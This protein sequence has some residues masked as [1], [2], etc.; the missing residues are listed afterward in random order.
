MQQ[1]SRAAVIWQL[2]A[3]VA[4]LLPHLSWLP[5]WLIATCGLTLGAR[6]MIHGGRWPLPHWSLKV[7]LVLLV[8]IGLLL[9][10][11]RETGMRATVALLIGGLALKMLEIY[12][13]RDA[14]VL[15][16]VALFV[17]GTTFL[18]H[19]SILVALYVLLAVTL[20]VAALNSIYQDP[21]RTD[22]WRPLKRAIR[23]LGFALPMMLV[24]FVL[25]PRIGP[26]WSVPLDQHAARSGLSEEMAPG[27]ISQLTKSAQLAFRAT[28]E[29]PPPAPEQRY[30]R[31]LVLSEFDGR[32]WRRAPFGERRRAGIEALSSTA[33]PI[34]YEV[35]FEPSNQRWL[36]ALD[37]PLS[38]S[39]GIRLGPQRTLVNER[40]LDRRISYSVRSALNYQLAERLEP[41]S[42]AA[43]LQLP[44]RGN[45]QSRAQAQS[46]W[47]E[48]G[49]DPAGFVQRVLRYFNQRFV[50]T[51]SPPALSDNTVDRF[52]FDTQAG[53]CG[54]YAGALAFLL[55]SV[56]VPARVVAGYQGGEWN[57][58]E[59]Y[60]T[61][62]QYDAHAWVEYWMAGEGW[63]RVDPTAAV[64]PE[65][66]RESADQVFADD[67]AFL[68]DTPLARLRFGHDS[69][70]VDVRRQLDAINFSWH[71]WVL[72]YQGQQMQL[73]SGLLGKISM[74]KLVLVLLGLM[75]PLLLIVAWVQLRPARSSS[76][77]PLERAQDRL[78]RELARQ[79]LPRMPQESLQTY[80]RR[81]AGDCPALA[82]E[83][84]R[85]ARADEAVRYG[86]AE[87][88]RRALL[89][90]IQT[91]YG[92]L[93]KRPVRGSRESH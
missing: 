37:Q 80:T 75:L 46:W 14:L 7:V 48:S 40:P 55:R 44:A 41:D 63:V 71:R 20:I 87:D 2:A 68:A 54:H 17:C 58:Y 13:R 57:S 33:S 3:F 59:Q 39:Q 26:L 53:F 16:Y 25:F 69:W 43:Y 32:T 83:L 86:G 50:Y 67:P 12:H 70:L 64:A 35:I 51:L 81:I 49:G 62:R 89:S 23:L 29:G 74:L 85:L 27:D 45:P 47:Q 4:V 30:W 18:F 5:W 78:L 72:N 24:L 1:I 34:R 66:I 9:T 22:L 76:R 90:A 10:F 93:R 28:F 82:S 19:Q 31:S 21:L 91:C 6:L 11:S 15:L 77:D 56:G 8:A 84:E 73:L 79:G 52:L 61:V 92:A 36:V 88:Q 42:R 38:A 65:R 60:L